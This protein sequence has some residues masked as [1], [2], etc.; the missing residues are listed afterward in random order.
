M[1]KRL[2][3]IF[4]FWLLALIC[5]GEPQASATNQPVWWHGKERELR[6]TPDGDAFVIRNGDQRFTRAIYGTNTAFRFETSDYPE[7]GLYMPDFGGSVYLA[8]SAPDTSVWLKDLA[9]VESRFVSGRRSYLLKD[10]RLLGEGSLTI[11]ALA[12]SDGDGFLLKV[13]SYNV[14]KSIRLLVVYGGANDR[15]FSRSGDIGADPASS[16]YIEPEKCRNNHF[17]LEGN[18]FLLTYGKK[19]KKIQGIFPEESRLRLSDGRKIN[20]LSDLL[21]SEASDFPLLVADYSLKVKAS[22]VLFQKSTEEASLAYSQLAD[23]FI[24]GEAFRKSVTERVRIQTPDPFLNTL[25]GILA[26]AEDAVWESPSYLHGAIGWRTPLTGWRGAYIADVFGLHDRARMHFD[27]YAASQLTQ[28]P[29]TLPHLQDTTANLARSQKT[30]GTPMYSN[31]YITRSPNSTSQMHHYDMNLVFIDALLWHLNWT[32]DIE[33][34]KKIFPVIKRHLAWEKNTFDPDNDGLYDGYCCI[35]ASD[36]LQYNG[37]VSTHSTA[38][39]FRANKMAAR[40]ARLTGENPVIYEAEANR[41]LT[42]LNQ[43]LWLKDKGWWAEFKDNMGNKRLHEHAAIWTIYHAIDSEVSDPFMAYQAARYVDTE[44][45]HI[46]VHAKKLGEMDNYVVSTTD[47]Q[48]YMWSIN[49]VAFAEVVHTALAFWQAGRVEEA[50]HLYK[51]AVLDAMYLGSG[52]GNITQVSFY[53]AARGET[54]RDFADPVAMAARALVQGL[55]G[56][57]PDLL[58]NKLVIRPGFPSDWNRATLETQ[59]MYYCFNRKGDTDRYQLIPKL[60]RQ[61]SLILEIP[62]RMDRIK[63][64]TINGRRVGFTI[65]DKSISSPKI[66]MDAGQSEAYDIV[67][68]WEGK[69]LDTR[70]TTISATTGSPLSLSLEGM[71]GDVYDPQNCVINE[72]VIEGNFYGIVNG[73]KG[74]RTLFVSMK[75][76]EMNWWKPI[77]IHI[78][79]ALELINDG[80]N[81]CLTFELVNHTGHQLAGKLVINETREGLPILLE[82][83]GKQVVS[84]NNDISCFGS[85]RIRFFTKD[86]TYQFEALNWNLKN[87]EITRYET[88]DFNDYLNERINNIFAYGKYLTPR[89]PYTTLQV[90]TQGMGQWCH[91]EALSKI[92]DSGIRKKAGS[93]NRFMMPQGIPFEIPGDSISRNIILTT[94]W[95]NYP[96]SVVVP[97]AGRAS[98]IYLLIAASTYH[99]QS[100]VENGTITAT[101]KDGSSD[102]LKLI[103]PDN[104]LPL[105]QHVFIDGFAFSCPNP[106]PYRISLKTGEVSRDQAALLGLSMSN[107]PMVIDGGLATVVDLLLDPTKTLSSITVKTTANE[108]IIGLM[109]ATLVR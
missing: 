38:Y 105:D 16:F 93:S 87:P 45:P 51:G 80:E 61:S 14:P 48:P 2:I 22:Y 67:V 47:W 60:S 28:V 71:S 77:D 23:A 29:V 36:G 24:K 37:G 94:L 6:Y 108:V 90:P 39:N 107:D 63:S 74:H 42:A 53:D 84:I 65:R 100:H 7:F 56:I 88:I 49:N 1:T 13:E 64:V 46:P 11:T 12:L 33:Y 20:Q 109:A 72:Q 50:Y 91:P 83:D 55:F 30:W 104:L 82:A 5:Q 17:Y 99:M 102:V 31:G 66:F 32:G 95:D 8:L 18:Q 58:N 103:L 27:A 78:Q 92:D 70:D 52:P 75:Q 57:V 97:V 73:C 10:T 25:G 85:N 89:W 68:I 43:T 4:P 96:D 79:D 69:P 34:A 98:R 44:I 62:A 26:G 81:S 106:R 40:I 21:S 35:W 86:T 3:T 15:R 41:I 19:G 101:Y 76:G 59:N 54:Y 9:M